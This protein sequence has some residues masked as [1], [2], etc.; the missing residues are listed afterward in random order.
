VD[1]QKAPAVPYLPMRLN[2]AYIHALVIVVNFTARHRKNIDSSETAFKPRKLKKQA[3]NSRYRDRAAERRLGEG[4][5]Y[6]HVTRCYCC[7]H[8]LYS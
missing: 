4:N 2:R 6:A 5:D 8:S 1:L 7:R 3:G